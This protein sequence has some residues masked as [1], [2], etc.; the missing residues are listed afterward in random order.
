MTLL[1]CCSFFVLICCKS[2]PTC[3]TMQI[4]QCK[5]RPNV[6]WASVHD[7]RSSS[8]VTSNAL[9]DPLPLCPLHCYPFPISYSYYSHWES[10]LLLSM[11]MKLSAWNFSHLLRLCLIGR[12]QE[13]RCGWWGKGVGR[14]ME[15][16]GRI[17]W[18]ARHFKCELALPLQSGP[19]MINEVSRSCP[20]SNPQHTRAR[21]WYLH[22]HLSHTLHTLHLIALPSVHIS[23]LCLGG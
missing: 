18:W 19:W 13:L 6:I 11:M 12:I 14:G 15:G 2:L 10:L 23:G 9:H 16:W 20:S 1:Q 22:A 8:A 21:C 3:W 5:S 7:R 17:V 4:I